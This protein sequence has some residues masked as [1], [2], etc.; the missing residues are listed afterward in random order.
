MAHGLEKSVIDNG[1]AYWGSSYIN[2]FSDRGRTKRIYMQ[3]NAPFRMSFEDF[4]K[5]RLRNSSGEMTPVSTFAEMD[6]SRGYPRLERY[7][8][9][10]ALKILG[11][12]APGKSSGDAMQTM[13]ELAAKLPDNFGFSWSGI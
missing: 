10:S 1:I 12:A 7:Q 3:A 13:R 2:D 6:E 4:D 5:Y 11:E 9:V 8:G